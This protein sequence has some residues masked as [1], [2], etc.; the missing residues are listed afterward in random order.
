MCGRQSLFKS[1]FGFEQKAK[2]LAKVILKVVFNLVNLPKAQ[3][4]IVS[5]WSRHRKQQSSNKKCE[6]CVSYNI[7]PELLGLGAWTQ[8]DTNMLYAWME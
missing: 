7:R 8:K 5:A 6:K 2:A 1:T 4:K 3:P